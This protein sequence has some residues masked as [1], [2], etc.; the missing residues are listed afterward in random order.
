MQ[1]LRRRVTGIEC[2]STHLD[3][4]KN[5]ALDQLRVES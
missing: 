3:A 1:L 2:Q 4:L 5:K